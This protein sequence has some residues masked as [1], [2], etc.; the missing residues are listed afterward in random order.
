MRAILLT[1]SSL[2]L[3]CSLSLA[4]KGDIA[5]ATG[6]VISEEKQ[7]LQL[8]KAPCGAVPNPVG[9]VKPWKKTIIGLRSCPSKNGKVKTYTEV[10]VEQL[11]EPPSSNTTGKTTDQQPKQP[12]TK[13][14]SPPTEANP[15]DKTPESPA[16]KQERHDPPDNSRP[17]SDVSH[18]PAA[19]SQSAEFH[20]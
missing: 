6:E 1:F 7:V 12:P 11:E 13:S 16:N 4:Q 20:R 3:F 14:D 2:T 10:Q 17:P 9:F 18:Q 5:V 15:S 19:F 8:N